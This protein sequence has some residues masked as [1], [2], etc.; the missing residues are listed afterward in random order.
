MRGCLFVLLTGLAL[1]VGV[2]WFAG[3]PIAGLGVEATLVSSGLDAEEIDVRVEAD[4]PLRLAIG[5]ADRIRIEATGVVWNEVRAG[6]LTVE[7]RDVDLIARTV[8]TAEGRLDDVELEQIGEDGKP[9]LIRVVFSGSGDRADTTVSIDRRT[10]ERLAIATF[11]AEI[12]N[13]PDDVALVSPDT[14]QFTVAGQAVR[15][16]LEV[17]AGGN[18]RATT[19]LGSVTILESGGLPLDLTDV[20][21]G[22]GGIELTGTFDVSSLI[23]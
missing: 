8:R 4:P 1:L 9:L 19:P 6:E 21:V 11:E 2:I 23:D 12:G 7:L 18:L 3:P 5:R 20:S 22:S 10:A 17:T 14:I 15:G 13:R 16:Q